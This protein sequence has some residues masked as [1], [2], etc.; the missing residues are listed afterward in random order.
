VYRVG[1]H[2]AVLAEELIEVSNVDD[3]GKPA[4][5]KVIADIAAGTTLF[6]PIMIQIKMAKC[7]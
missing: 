5:V 4:H 3:P 1:A 6:L 2:L 7:A